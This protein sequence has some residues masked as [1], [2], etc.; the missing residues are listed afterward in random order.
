MMRLPTFTD[1][2]LSRTDY[3]LDFLESERR[4]ENRPAPVERSAVAQRMTVFRCI[5]DAAKSTMPRLR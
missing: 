4:D 2:R 1:T 3:V 5:G